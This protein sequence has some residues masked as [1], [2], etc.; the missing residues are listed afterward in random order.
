VRRVA[1]VLSVTGGNRKIDE[2][3]YLV[4]T[5]GREVFEVARRGGRR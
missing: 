3:A 4:F 5:F 2:M 1:I